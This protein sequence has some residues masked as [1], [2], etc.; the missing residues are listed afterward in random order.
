MIITG[1]GNYIGLGLTL[2][3]SVM[4]ALEPETPSSPTPAP[5]PS[6]VS[7]APSA[8]RWEGQQPYIGPLAT[9]QNISP[10]MF[11][12]APVPTSLRVAPSIYQT[13]GTPYIGPF[14]SPQNIAPSF[15][16]TSMV[17][18][19]YQNVWGQP[20]QPGWQ[21]LYSPQ[22]M[23]PPM[24]PGG[25]CPPGSM[26]GKYPDTC[27]PVGEPNQLVRGET[28]LRTPVNVSTPSAKAAEQAARDFD[29]SPNGSGGGGGLSP[30]MLLAVGAA[31]L[32]LLWK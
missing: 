8:F 9:P 21:Q 3:K 10:E 12:P 26:A 6:V 4:S 31:A 17:V 19:G 1:Y 18:G 11:A 14:A 32:L 15:L 22:Y 29:L 20:G 23:F 28:L 13:P 5:T 2:S 27:I 7:L 30:V 24:V 25:P 16:P